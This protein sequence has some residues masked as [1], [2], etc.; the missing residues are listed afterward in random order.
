MY[1][2]GDVVSIN[3]S[4]CGPP[5]ILRCPETS[6]NLAPRAARSALR[7]R[8]TV[9]YFVHLTAFVLFAVAGLLVFNFSSLRL[10]SSYISPLTTVSGLAVFKMHAFNR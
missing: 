9:Y 3:L 8:Y 1:R 7:A 10:F 2:S 4:A 6:D 5:D